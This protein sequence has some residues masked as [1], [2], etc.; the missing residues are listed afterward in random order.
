MRTKATEERRKVRDFPFTPNHLSAKVGEPGEGSFERPSPVVAPLRAAVL[1][2][3]ASLSLSILAD[4]FD[5]RDGS[6]ERDGLG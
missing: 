6:A 3:L 1:G 2:R 5:A 4:P